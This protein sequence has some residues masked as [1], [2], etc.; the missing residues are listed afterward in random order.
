MFVL[1]REPVVIDRSD[2]S[3][4]CCPTEI[5]LLEKFIHTWETLQPDIITGWN[6][7][8]Y[9]I[10]YLTRRIESVMGKKEVKRL[11]VWGFTRQKT[12][13]VMNREEI[14]CVIGGLA[15]LDYL[16]LYRKFTYQNQESY[17]LDHIA[18]VELGEKKLSYEEHDSMHTFYKKDYQKFIEYNIKDVELVSRLEDKMKLIELAVVMAYDA[19]INYEDVFGQTRYWDAMIYNHLRRK[20]VVV[21]RKPDD[22]EKPKLVGA[23]VK[24]IPDNGISSD[25]PLKH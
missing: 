24:E 19:G 8:M 6:S 3:Y 11:S 9:D 14:V 23:Y 7:K 12:V 17:K 4:I 18:F 15:Q 16:D 2:V 20:N 13:K 22:A 25:C 10:P 21:P 5:E 1:G